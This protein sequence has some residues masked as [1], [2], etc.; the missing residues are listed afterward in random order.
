MSDIRETVYE[1]CSG[2][3]TFTMTAAERW[4]I[5]MIYRLKE[6]FPEQVDIR[7]TNPDGSMVVHL[8][9]EWM[10]IVPKK[11]SNLTDEQK[12]ALSER[13]KAMVEQNAL[14]RQAQLEENE[15]ICDE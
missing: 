1:H 11:K 10:R 6:R 14:R 4:S 2:D 13:A 9:F 7:H 15:Q 5:A 3:S 12:Q 8:P